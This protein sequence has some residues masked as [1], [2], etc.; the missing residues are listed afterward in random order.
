MVIFIKLYT[1][2]DF[3]LDVDILESSPVPR[4]HKDA[5]LWKLNKESKNDF[6]YFMNP[7]HTLAQTT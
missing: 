7:A 5:E 6:V 1:Y 4:H 3:V 2:F